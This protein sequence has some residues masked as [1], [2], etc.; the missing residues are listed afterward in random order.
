M[1]MVISHHR[2]AA[3]TG[4]AMRVNQSLR[5]YFEV[6][7]WRSRHIGSAFVD[8]DH[9]HIWFQPAQQQTACLLRGCA[10][11]FLHQR[12]DYRA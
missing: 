3:S 7:V 8:A 9:G 4:M 6:D 10:G 1:R 11:G 12:S 5:V 2:R